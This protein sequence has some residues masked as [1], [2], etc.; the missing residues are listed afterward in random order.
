MGMA[1][2]YGESLWLGTSPNRTKSLD[3]AFQKTGFLVGW[4]GGSLELI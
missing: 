1:L 2:G 3:D 4:E